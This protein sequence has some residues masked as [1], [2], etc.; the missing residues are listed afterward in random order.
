VLDVHDHPGLQT[1]G[2]GFALA[3]ADRQALDDL[4][5]ANVAVFERLVVPSSTFAELCRLPSD[6]VIVIANGADTGLIIPEPMPAEP[7]VA[8]ISGAAPGRGIELLVE[9]MVQVRAEEPPANLHLALAVTGPASAAYLD[10]LRSDLA[11]RQPWVSIDAVPYAALGRFLGAASV[12]VIP[13]PPNA[14]LDAAT[15]VKLFDSMAAGRPVVVTPRIETAAIVRAADAGIVTES[16]R[17][18]DLAAGILALLRDEP[19]RRALG[20][21]ARR[22]AVD[23]YDWHVLASE[24]ADVVLR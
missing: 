13:H 3:P 10:A 16:D 22:A 23:R 21:N 1:D 17:V 11:G 4:F 18:D 15:P 14:Y 6:R 7:V 5:A 2:L 24:L 19:R 20:E 8:M 12:L 9:A